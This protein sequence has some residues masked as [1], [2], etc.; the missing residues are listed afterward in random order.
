MSC[1][2]LTSQFLAFAFFSSSFASLA[3]KPAQPT[4]GR[5][6]GGSFSDTSFEDVRYVSS[7]LLENL[8]GHEGAWVPDRQKFVIPDSAGIKWYFTLDNPYMN[9]GDEVFNLGFPVRRGPEFLFLP[10]PSLLR[11]LEKRGYVVNI[12]EPVQTE[13]PI[14][15]PRVDLEKPAKRPKAVSSGANLIDVLAEER[16]NGTLVTLKTS[17]KLDWESF[18]VPP[19]FILKLQGGKVLPQFPLKAPGQGLVKNILTIQEKDLVQVTLYIPKVIDTVE[20]TYSDEAQAYQILIHK[21]TNKPTPPP[22]DPIPV[23]DKGSDK[24]FGTIII[25]PGHGGKDPGAQISG[26][27][28]ADVTLAVGRDLKIALAKLGFKALLT[29]EG[30]QFIELKDRPKFASNQGGDLFI[31][32]HCNSIG[33]SPKRRKSVTGFTAYILREGESKNKIVGLK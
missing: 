17:G 1:K 32:L 16:D 3:L 26:V 2:F 9:V 19:H 8:F 18:W 12:S 10:L 15:N 11:I 27:N 7:Q 13:A 5:W 29:R 24:T 20:T 28:E 22:A 23:E 21:K 31:S 25:D 4:Q 14:A 6:T 33:G 30:D